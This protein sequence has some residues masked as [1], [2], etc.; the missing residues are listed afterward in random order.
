MQVTEVL[1][2][3]IRK[4]NTLRPGIIYLLCDVVLI[5]KGKFLIILN[6]KKSVKAP[7]G[8]NVGQQSLMFSYTV[9]FKN[10][11]SCI[12]KMRHVTIIIIVA[13]VIKYVPGFVVLINQ[14]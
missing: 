9:T 12:V 2:N 13:V 3:F 7:L 1:I 10:K 11:S 5:I 8:K 14:L 4:S 6:F